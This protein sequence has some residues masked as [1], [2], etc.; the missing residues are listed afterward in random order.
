MCPASSLNY[1][2]TITKIFAKRHEKSL[3]NPR[4]HTHIYIPTVGGGGGAG[5]MKPRRGGCVMLQCFVTILP[6]MDSL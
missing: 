5:W 6:L 1:N 2:G 4:T 3:I